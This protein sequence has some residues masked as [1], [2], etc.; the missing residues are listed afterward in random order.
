MAFLYLKAEND[1]QLL[2]N[3]KLVFKNEKNAR[4][5]FDIFSL[6]EKKDAT[7]LCVHRA[8]KSIFPSVRKKISF[9]TKLL[10]SL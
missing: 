8:D 5:T 6:N 9:P 4:T 1:I 10:Q 3:G 7:S 2:F